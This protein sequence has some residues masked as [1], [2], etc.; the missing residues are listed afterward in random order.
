MNHISVTWDVSKADR[1]RSVR[2]LQKEN[3]LFIV[4]TLEVSSNEARFSIQV[5]FVKPLL[6]D[7]NENI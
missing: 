3:I 1:S 6:L 2:T 4:L 5:S 7:L